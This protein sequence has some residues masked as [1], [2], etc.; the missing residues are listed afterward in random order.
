MT[1]YARSNQME[2]Y[3]EVASF[4]MSDY[5]TPGGVETYIGNQ[6]LMVDDQINGWNASAGPVAWSGNCNAKMSSSLRVNKETGD[7]VQASKSA[8]L[9]LEPSEPM[10][11]L[12]EL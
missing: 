2:N 10:C 4:A 8:S 12:P 1:E 5:L 11:V 9:K 3:A 6:V 7:L